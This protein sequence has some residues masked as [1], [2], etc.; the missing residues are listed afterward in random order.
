VE[1]RARFVGLP[2][3]SSSTEARSRRSF[4]TTY[5]LQGTEPERLR[6]AIRELEPLA[7]PARWP[8]SIEVVVTRAAGPRPD[9]LTFV[10]AASAKGPVEAE[11]CGQSDCVALDSRVGRMLIVDAGDRASRIPPTAEFFRVE[12][13]FRSPDGREENTFSHLYLPSQRLMA[14]GAELPGALAWFP[15]VG[16]PLAAIERAVNELDPYTGPAAWPRSLEDAMVTRTRA[17]PT[18]DWLLYVLAACGILVLISAAGFARRVR[19][20][21]ARAV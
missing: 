3:A 8:E 7:P 21:Q 6:Q 18:G 10:A 11:I 17:S 16:E 13:T 4:S 15:V 20:R 19:L 12:F 5:A 2:N 1:R 14:A 9:G